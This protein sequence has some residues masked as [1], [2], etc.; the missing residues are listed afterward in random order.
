M[1]TPFDS[2]HP[3]RIS[4]PGAPPYPAAV[5]FPSPYGPDETIPP[6]PPYPGSATPSEAAHP[7]GK[8]E[9][10][11]GSGKRAPQEGLGRRGRVHLAKRQR[12]IDATAVGQLLLQL[13]S[14]LAGLVIVATLSHLLFPG[15]G[16]LGI[17][18]WLGSGAMAFHRP[19]ERALARHLLNLRHPTPGELN[20]LE[21]LWREV[22]ARTGVEG[23]AYE[24]WIEDSD[25]LNAL[26]AAGHIVGVTRFS[27]E[28]LSDGQLAAV[29]AHELGHHVRGHAWSLILGQ[30]YAVPGRFAWT[31]VRRLIRLVTVVGRGRMSFW[32]AAL[33]LAVGA[34]VLAVAWEYWFLTL[35]LVAAPYLLAAVTRRTELRADHHAVAAGFGPML[36]EVLHLMQ[37]TEREG[38]H[39]TASALSGCGK[40]AGIDLGTAARGGRRS[41]SGKL[42]SSHPDYYTRLH[43]L[44]PY[45]ERR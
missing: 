44:A 31:A 1:I 13:P 39:A 24:L 17:L 9:P 41:L 22:T 35:T 28:R 43:H 26:A 23:R 12:G 21:P 27:L 40:T 33:F 5:P 25:H 38:G 19:T 42:L 8:P 37:A 34:I 29:L 3:G 32:A 6:P 18:L 16:W 10:Q 36:A 30:W 2:T 11:S 45:L 7:A 20:R 15:T 4:L 14:F